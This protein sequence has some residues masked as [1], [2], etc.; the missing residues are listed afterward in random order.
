[1]FNNI[2]V[3]NI[4]EIFTVTSP[5][6]RCEHMKSRRCYGLSFCIEGQITY[7]QNE[8]KVVSDTSCAVLLPMGQE[9]TIHGDK[10]GIFPV[11]NFSCAE[12]LCTEVTALPVQNNG[13]FLKDFEKLKALSL[14]SQ[15]R[16]EMMSVF[17]HILHRLSSL[18]LPCKTI[19]PAV[20]YIEENYSDSELNIFRLAA[21]CNISEIYFRR[22]FTLHFKIPPK[23]YLLNIRIN[24]AKQLLSE[25]ALKINVIAR[26]CGFSGQYHFC[27]IF[28]EKTGLTP[29][30]FMKQNLI[31]KI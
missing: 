22:L 26:Q 7:I 2:T 30:E 25:G 23:Q 3:T 21:M 18:G 11:I 16:A 9:Y 8:K 19:M 24:K 12:K 15:N 28:K 31:Y 14:F 1:M 17:Y 10:S 4:E 5:K 13:E 27:R 20:R 6:G 29:T